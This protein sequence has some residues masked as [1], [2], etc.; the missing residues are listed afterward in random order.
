MGGHAPPREGRRSPRLTGRR[1]ATGSDAMESHHTPD[2]G[3][4]VADD[5][6][7]NA[8]KLDCTLPS[9]DPMAT[10]GATGA[11]GGYNKKETVLDLSKFIDKS[12]RVKLAGGREG[13][14]HQPRVQQWKAKH[15]VAFVTAEARPRPEPAEPCFG[16]GGLEQRSLRIL[17][18][19]GICECVSF[20]APPK[21]SECTLGRSGLAL[22]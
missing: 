15:G 13:A 18:P 10:T 9:S 20:A 6:A 19:W 3:R 22:Q 1:L 11:T 16:R 4:P 8:Y 21:E 14:L 5:V 2:D 7:L 12:V 17:S